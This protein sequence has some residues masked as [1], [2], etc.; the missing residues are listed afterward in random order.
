MLIGITGD[1]FP[2]S[3]NMISVLTPLFVP[4][5]SSDKAKNFNATVQLSIIT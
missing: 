3:M 4:L 5:I 1:I 2:W